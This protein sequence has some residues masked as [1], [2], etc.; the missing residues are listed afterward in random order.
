VGRLEHEL[1]QEFP[2]RMALVQIFERRSVPAILTRSPSVTAYSR[3]GQAIAGEGQRFAIVYLP[4]RL[5]AGQGAPLSRGGRSERRCAAQSFIYVAEQFR[6]QAMC[7]CGFVR[8]RQATLLRDRIPSCRRDPVAKFR[9]QFP[10]SAMKF[11]RTSGGRAVGGLAGIDQ[12]CI[13]VRGR[14]RRFVSN[15]RAL[16]QQRHRQSVAGRRRFMHWLSPRHGGGSQWYA[17][18]Q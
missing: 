13:V 2:N 11:A 12:A 1:G 10:T 9:A 6:R 15:C 5:D 14:Q 4:T 3:V 8:P 18:E 17:G 16:F 7:G